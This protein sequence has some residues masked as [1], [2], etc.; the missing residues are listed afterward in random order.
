MLLYLNKLEINLRPAGD[1]GDSLKS[2][3]GGENNP[4]FGKTKSEQTLAKLRKMIFV[5]ASSIELAPTKL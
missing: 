4:M 2:P 3:R 1:P 5:G